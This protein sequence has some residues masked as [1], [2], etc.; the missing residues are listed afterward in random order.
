MGGYANKPLLNPMK[1]SHVV[2]L[3]SALSRQASVFPANYWT[4]Y[5]IYLHNIPNGWLCW[6]YE[7]L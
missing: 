1:L 6:R 4:D 2:K 5:W 3:I 7:T